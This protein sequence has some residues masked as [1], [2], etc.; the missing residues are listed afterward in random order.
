MVFREPERIIPQ[1]FDSSEQPIS[2][3][4]FRNSGMVPNYAGHVHGRFL[5]TKLI[6][7]P[8]HYLHYIIVLVDFYLAGRLRCR[9]SKCIHVHNFEYVITAFAIGRCNHFL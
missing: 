2:F 1:V 5:Q 4:V 9:P 7:N 8:F 3:R 6:I